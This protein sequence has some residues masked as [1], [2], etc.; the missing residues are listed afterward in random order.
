MDA[1][2]EFYFGKVNCMKNCDIFSV[3][4]SSVFS[5]TL[6]LCKRM[7]SE[8]RDSWDV[9]QIANLHSPRSIRNVNKLRMQKNG[10]CNG[11]N[12]LDSPKRNLQMTDWNCQNDF[13][14][15]SSLHWKSTFF[16]I[17]FDLRRLLCVVHTARQK[18]REDINDANKQQC[19]ET[20]NWIVNGKNISSTDYSVFASL[21]F[22]LNII[23]NDFPFVISRC[24]LTVG[25]SCS[26]IKCARAQ[27][28]FARFTF[29]FVLHEWNWIL[30]KRTQNYNWNAVSP[31]ISHTALRD[32]RAYM[33]ILIIIEIINHFHC[34]T[35]SHIH[36]P[37]QQQ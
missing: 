6:I 35:S 18:C 23:I 30:R 11:I 2:Y 33:P 13:V 10:K 31:F 22:I 32:A 20:R 4:Q 5:S 15:H 1:I 16:R 24:V 3:R 26:C 8:E 25:A 7:N 17:N 37:F 12:F 14:S 21:F 36:R 19:R 27:S 34:S 28:A 29:H 9:M